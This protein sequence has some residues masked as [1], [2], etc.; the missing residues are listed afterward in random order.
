MRG[1]AVTV[2]S[3]RAW[4]TKFDTELTMRRARED[5]EKMKGLM[6][7]EKEEFKR[8]GTRLTGTCTYA[9]RTRA[10][11]LIGSGIAGRQL[12]ERNRN[13]EEDGLMEEGTISVDISQYERTRTS[14]EEVEED[15]VTFSDSD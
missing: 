2:E 11:C 1:T 3:F 9:Q 13:L 8:I 7:K 14:A 12:F 4:K 10:A 5:E 15:R 6:P